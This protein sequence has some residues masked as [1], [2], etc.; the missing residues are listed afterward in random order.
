MP[1]LN[2]ADTV[3]LTGVA[4]SGVSTWC[5]YRRARTISVEGISLTTWYQFILM[6][7]FWVSYGLAEH[8]PIVIAGS[9]LCFPWQMAIVARLSPHRH[10]AH[11]AVGTAFVSL[12]C[13]VPTIA[14]G[15]SAGAVG[16][17]VAM[18]VNR[19]PQIIDLLRYPRD[20]GVSVASWAIGGVCSVAWI[21]YYEFAHLWAALAATAAGMIGNILIASLASW[22]HRQRT[23]T[24]EPGL[25][26]PLTRG[27][28][29]LGHALQPQ[30]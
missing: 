11:V 21:G 16:C 1:T 10:L 12:C 24:G 13:A 9:V 14:F 6:G 17:G 22:R 30:G 18:A 26:R 29:H 23:T 3:G 8:A 15:W 19:L 4:L 25:V 2:L 20:L 5:Q 28:E 27:A 7:V